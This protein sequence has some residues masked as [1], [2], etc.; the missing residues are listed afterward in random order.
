MKYLLM[1]SFLFLLGMPIKGFGAEG[2][3]RYEL[4]DEGIKKRIMSFLIE[5]IGQ[6][7]NFMVEETGIPGVYIASFGMQVVYISSDLK[8]V[9]K[10]D[11]YNTATGQN[12]TI[13]AK[14]KLRALA[15]ESLDDST[16]ISFLATDLKN[17][18][19][20]IYVF[21]DVDCGYCRKFHKEVVRLNNK[22]INVYYLAFPRAGQEGSTYEKMVSVWCS[23]NR[24]EALSVAK[25]GRK[26][27]AKKCDN[28][29]SEHFKLGLE[30]ELK[31]TPAVFSS[32]G[33]ELGGF[34]EA[35]DIERILLQ[36]KS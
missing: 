32:S 27:P 30:I 13:E 22:G 25:K 16:M 7:H 21:T 20:N 11:L 1:I 4:N 8:F 9:F 29:I 34:I 14:K 19:K 12:I 31:G 2:L 15:F 24:N 23:S 28:P 5:S 10:G 33:I 26:I 17:T 35:K 6:E 3:Q 36:E 18:K